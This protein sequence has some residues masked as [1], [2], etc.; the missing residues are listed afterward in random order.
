[1]INYCF[2]RF[3]IT[4]RMLTSY[5]RIS[6]IN[7]KS[8][9][10]RQSFRDEMR[11]ENMSVIHSGLYTGRIALRRRWMILSSTSLVFLSRLGGQP[12]SHRLKVQKWHYKWD[13]FSWNPISSLWK[14]VRQRANPHSGGERSESL[15][16]Y[17]SRICAFLFNF[18]GNN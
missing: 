14:K 2:F 8:G 15:E 18:F 1:M 10:R 5:R 16:G 3:K 4:I 12:S 11:L 9:S 7:K 13:W 17:N 6:G